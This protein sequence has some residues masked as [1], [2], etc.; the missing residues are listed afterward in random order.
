MYV[1]KKSFKIL[2][3]FKSVYLLQ[4]SRQDY[5]LLNAL[6]VSR[7]VSMHM[8]GVRFFFVDR[9][10]ATYRVWNAGNEGGATIG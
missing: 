8:H 10:L 7:C 5:N 6:D 4:Q 9:L 2:L 1:N 3:R